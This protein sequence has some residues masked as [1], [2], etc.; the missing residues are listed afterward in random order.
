[1]VRQTSSPRARRSSPKPPNV[2]VIKLNQKQQDKSDWT[3]DAK[4]VQRK[5]TQDTQTFLNFLAKGKVMIK[6]PNYWCHHPSHEQ[7]QGVL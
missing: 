6:D 5:I 7:H 4:T 2:D 3:K 1:M